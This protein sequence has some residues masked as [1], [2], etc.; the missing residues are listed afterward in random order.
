[1]PQKKGLSLEHYETMFEYRVCQRCS[2][3]IRPGT[4]VHWIE[5]EDGIPR[6]YHHGCH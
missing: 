6:P 5:D 4:V 2:V 1:M 3:P